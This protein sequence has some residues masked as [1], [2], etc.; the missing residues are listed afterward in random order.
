MNL[1]FAWRY[2][3]S[4]K[5]TNAINVIA[6][7][8]VVAIAFV[9]AALIVVL[10]VFN[11]FEDLVKGLYNDFYAD[12]KVTAASGKWMNIPPNQL[13]ELE[14]VN[15]VKA[16]APVAEERAIL[17]DDENKS[18]VWLKGVEPGY[19]NVSGVPK[20]MIAGNF[21][22]GNREQ[23]VLV[24]GAGVENALQINADRNLYPVTIYLPNRKSINPADPL[25]ALHSNSAATAGTF[26]IQQEFD[27]QY[28]F[29]D[30]RFMQYML[31]LQ[32]TQYS[33]LEVYVAGETPL[34]PVQAKLKS[35][36]G[37][38]FVVR[39][40]Y[41]QNQNLF[42]AMQI[43]RLVI[44][45]V[46]FLILIIAAF[47]IIGC[48]TMMVLEKQKDIAVLKAMGAPDRTIKR[49][50]LNEGFLLAGIGGFIGIV[51]ALVI[52]WGQ[53]H[54]HWI[55]LGGQSFII[56]YYPVSMQWT[57]FLLVAAIIF[58]IAFIAAYI[59]SRKAAA[60]FYSLKS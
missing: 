43:E 59:P 48:L 10:S 50:F 5:N 16:I 55:K 22:T 15:G 25:D 1:L 31:D 33:S 46:A 32:P 8:S 56:D 38:S 35:I 9:T 57:D 23:P 29:T 53:S 18:I 12:V 7:I 60:N 37:K 49:I 26:V 30:M 41:E 34:E 24:L 6:W 19:G 4:K 13:A 17:V 14:A 39:N 21:V 40:R 45:G 20:H 27:N 2:F 47:N 51:I 3:R 44:Y 52:C 28:A 42:A 11:G 54:F 58:I 36:L